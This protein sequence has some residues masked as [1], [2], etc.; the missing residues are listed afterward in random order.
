MH[1][2]NKKEIRFSM[3]G[4]IVYL[5]VLFCLFK[6]RDWVIA[7][8]LIVVLVCGIEVYCTCDIN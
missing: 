4:E 7:E 2:F 3:K 6:H 8:L 1:Q 5:F